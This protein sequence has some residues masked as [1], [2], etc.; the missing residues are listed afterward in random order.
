MAVC[1]LYL[2][3][4]LSLFSSTRFYFSR[5]PDSGVAKHNISYDHVSHVK[6]GD[7]ARAQTGVKFNGVEIDLN[8]LLLE[9]LPKWTEA[10]RPSAQY[11]KR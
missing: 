9:K 10:M 11:C 4:S 3:A 7:G 1:N 6:H 5:V 2:L 8:S